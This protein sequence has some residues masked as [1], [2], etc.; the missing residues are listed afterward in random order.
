MSLI[1]LFPIAASPSLPLA[2]YRIAHT[3]SA[4][5]AIQYILR[6]RPFLVPPHSVYNRS[7]GQALAVDRLVTGGIAGTE[8]RILDRELYFP[9]PIPLAKLAATGNTVDLTA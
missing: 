3:P 2:L 6:P 9:S 8:L 4:R 7:L 1:P 5:L